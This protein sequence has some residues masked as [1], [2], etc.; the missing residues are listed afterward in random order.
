MIDAPANIDD[1]QLKELHLKLDLWYIKIPLIAGFFNTFISSIYLNAL[2][3][4][5]TVY[6][7]S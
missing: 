5:K 1:E 3:Q 7:I 6:P 4:Q 2:Q